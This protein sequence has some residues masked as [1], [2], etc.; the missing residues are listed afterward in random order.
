V[1][2]YRTYVRGR[3]RLILKRFFAFLEMYDVR[4]I[5]HSH[6]EDHD[7]L[8]IT[9]SGHRHDRTVRMKQVA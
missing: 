3:V 8:H 5:P 1:Y 2:W 4:L 6:E 7:I 9:P